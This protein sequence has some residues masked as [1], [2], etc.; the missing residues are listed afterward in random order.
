M[1]LNC[2]VI[3]DEP[4]A[5]LHIEN[6]IGRMACLKLTGSARNASIAKTILDNEAIDLV[7]LDIKMPQT[8]G[9]EFIREN[10][11][12]QQVILVTAFPEF[13]LDGFELDVTDY[14][15]KP[16]TFERFETAVE[17]VYRRIT[18]FDNIR[19]IKHQHGFCY[20]KTG[21]RYEK[22]V[23]DDILYIESM[24]NYIH[25]ITKTSKLTVYSS[26]K[27]VEAIFPKDIFVR[28]HKSYLAAITKINTIELKHICIGDHK[29][30]VSRGNR[31][32]VVEAARKMGLIFSD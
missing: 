21:Q 5:R 9:L 11:M 1:I 24:L 28:I 19:K 15:M 25:I 26:L 13:A 31:N 10:N 3:D 23:F 27:N 20:V 18:G 6:Y 14:L 32:S 22:V 17:K 2:L 29:I 16:V 7:F 4:L 12:F 8:S 30:P